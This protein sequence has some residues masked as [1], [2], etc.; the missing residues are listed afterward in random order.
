MILGLASKTCRVII[1]SAQHVSFLKTDEDQ[2]QR[3]IYCLA[4][5]R[6]DEGTPCDT[7]PPPNIISGSIYM[8]WHEKSY[9]II[10]NSGL[11]AAL[12]TESQM[13][14]KKSLS[15]LVFTEMMTVDS[16]SLTP[17]KIIHQIG[18]IPKKNDIFNLIYHDF[19][20]Q[21]LSRDLNW[22]MWMTYLTNCAS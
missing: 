8:N 15:V 14:G 3:N 16:L 9:F 20:L 17:F 12:L 11:T 22:Q 7:L 1:L 13:T 4:S 2:N 5:K 21:I 6:W 10:L 18:E 19:L